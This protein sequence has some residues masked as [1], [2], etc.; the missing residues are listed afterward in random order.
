MRK[1]IS[2]VAALIIVTAS[3]IASRM[4]LVEG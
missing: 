4:T 1:H 3:V 2:I